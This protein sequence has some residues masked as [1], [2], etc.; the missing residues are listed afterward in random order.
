MKITVENLLKW[1]DVAEKARDMNYALQEVEND[2]FILID[3]ST[4]EIFPYEGS[5][6]LNEA[7]RFLRSGIE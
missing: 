5:Y 1:R 7:E 3:R 6:T 4:G 2:D